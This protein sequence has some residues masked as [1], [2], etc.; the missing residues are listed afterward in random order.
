MTAA[1]AAAEAAAAEARAA[2]ASAAA[3]VDAGADTLDEELDALRGR[4]RRADKHYAVMY[5]RVVASRAMHC[6]PHS[7]YFTTWVVTVSCVCRSGVARWSSWKG[8]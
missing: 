8:S 6:F 2:A 3:G 7:S 4:L 5:V 1:V